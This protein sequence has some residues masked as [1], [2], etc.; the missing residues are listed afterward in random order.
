VGRSPF[1]AL[2]RSVA[3]DRCITKRPFP[4]HPPNGPFTDLLDP[5]ENAYVRDR[6]GWVRDRVAVF[7]W[8]KQREILEAVVRHR[9]VA[10]KSAHDTGTGHGASRAVGWW[11]DTR[12]KTRLQRQLPT[13]KQVHAILWR[14]SAGL[15]AGAAFL[16]ASRSMAS[17]NRG[18]GGKSSAG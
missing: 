8:S 4:P 7:L 6:V 2:G 13:T 14:S 15:I 16:A 1:G 10:V 3:L 17:S 18:P 12:E 11:L 9:Y 5:P